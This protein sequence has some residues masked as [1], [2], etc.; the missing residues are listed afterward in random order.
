LLF[1]M[2]AKEKKEM[3]NGPDDR[4]AIFDT[5]L[6]DGEQA[7]GYSMTLDEKTR[8]AEQ[9]DLLGVDVIEAGFAVASPGDFE[10]VRRV[11]ETVSSAVVAS[12][13]R[14]VE[15]DIDAAIDA[16]SEPLPDATLRRCR[17]A[18]AVLLGAVGGPKWDGLPVRGVRSARCSACARDWGSRAICGPSSCG[19]RSRTRVR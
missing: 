12:L 4:V 14:A 6:R 19:A 16:T 11:S 2:P 13:S 1:F 5:T 8:L 9:L 10:S 3:D 18:D 15:K 7:P 17:A